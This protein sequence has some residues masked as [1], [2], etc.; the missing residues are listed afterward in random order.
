M[1]FQNFN[2][3]NPYFFVK[4][5]KERTFL[6][7]HE[8][9]S[10]LQE[11]LCWCWLFLFLQN[12]VAIK[13]P[14]MSGGGWRCN[15]NL[16]LLQFPEASI[17]FLNKV[18]YTQKPHSKTNVHVTKLHVL[19]IIPQ[20]NQTNP[21]RVAV[22][23]FLGQSTDFPVLL[24]PHSS[25]YKVPSHLPLS[26]SYSIQ[27]HFVLYCLLLLQHSNNTI[28]PPQYQPLEPLTL[29]RYYVFPSL[30]MSY[31]LNCSNSGLIFR[32]CFV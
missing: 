10:F 27:K 28:W 22:D 18:H 8:K 20:H 16:K 26:L 12:F 24:L 21:T 3:S 9:S 4:K 19:I 29:H 30:I 14:Y 32:T 2:F 5:K 17:L 11:E 1:L 31:I 7:W 13:M 6:K 15:S 25:H 23:K